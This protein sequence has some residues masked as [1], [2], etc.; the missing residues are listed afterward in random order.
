[1]T[2]ERRESDIMIAPARARVAKLGRES[3]E[4]LYSADTHLQQKDAEI[5]EWAHKLDEA[6]RGHGDNWERDQGARSTLDGS[7]HGSAQ[8]L[9]DRAA[10]SRHQLPQPL[11][12]SGATPAD[13]RTLVHLDGG[14]APTPA[15]EEN[16]SLL[17]LN[18]LPP[19]GN[20]EWLARKRCDGV[21]EFAR[22]QR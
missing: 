22:V 16:N 3:K 21:G 18:T 2:H 10:A 6:R 1:M 4:R 11:G 17:L 15:R 13:T 8:S 7:A 14:V 9:F 19:C 12:P 20:L 5:E